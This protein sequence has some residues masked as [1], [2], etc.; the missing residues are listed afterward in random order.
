[1]ARE[2]LIAA[3]ESCGRYNPPKIGKIDETPKWYIIFN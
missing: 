2:A 3:K 1:M